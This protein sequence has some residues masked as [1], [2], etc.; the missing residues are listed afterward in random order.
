MIVAGHVLCSV[1]SLQFGCHRPPIMIRSGIWLMVFNTTFNNICDL[2][3]HS[4]CQQM[5]VLQERWSIKRCFCN[6]INNENLYI[7]MVSLKRWSL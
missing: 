5:I 4:F 3:N 7:E 1:T 6:Y 2:V